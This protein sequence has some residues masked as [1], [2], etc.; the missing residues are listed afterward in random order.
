[1]IKIKKFLFILFL[2]IF[3]IELIIFKLLKIK[4]SSI[5]YQAMINY[6]MITRGWSNTL[7]HMLLKKNLPKQ[8]K[9]DLQINN[10]KK[11]G[12]LVKKNFYTKEFILNFN[13]SLKKLKGYWIGD[14]YKSK[15]KEKLHKK[16]KS[17][18]FF[19]ES[20]DL[21][22]LKPV[23]EILCNDYLFDIASR[24]LDAEPI[25]YNI[26]CWYNFPTKLAD[27][28]AA[29]LWHFDMDRPKW[30]KIFIY[31]SNCNKN[32]G[33]HCF[34]QG[35]HLDGSIFYEILSLGYTRIQDV[36]V[37]KLYKTK[38]KEF[39]FKEGDLLFEDS[40]G[41]HKGKKVIS[42]NRLMFQI[43]FTSSLFGNEYNIPI[44]K[45]SDC[46]KKFYE[47]V[48]SRRHNYQGIKII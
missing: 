47:K 12:Y 46:T 43:E 15:S 8:N 3:L 7:I 44:I 11:H 20:E 4:N 1:M 13:N 29:Q 17:A 33:P 5:S 6:F 10:F 34:V 30:I 26:N 48:I 2:P 27:K 14:K 19:Y 25:L 16:I 38:I 18:K 31:L 41:L 39:N 45:K 24:Y 22:K 9:L 32:N 23:Q 35:T 37:N 42:K 40:R 28:E 36:V 21:I